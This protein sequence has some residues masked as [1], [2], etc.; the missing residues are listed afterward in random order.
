MKLDNVAK[1]LIIQEDIVQHVAK[2][3]VNG[4]LMVCDNGAILTQFILHQVY[5]AISV[6]DDNI[7][8]YHFINL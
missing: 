6:A 3:Q 7:I 4:I 2:M 1:N 5:G 8:L